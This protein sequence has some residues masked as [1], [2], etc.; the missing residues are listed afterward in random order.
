MY[1]WK[2]AKETEGIEAAGPYSRSIS[3]WE[4]LLRDGTTSSNH[5]RMSR[6]SL[7]SDVAH[8]FT[9]LFGHLRSGFLISTGH[10][11]VP[12]HA[13]RHAPRDP[14]R[15]RL[16][17]RAALLRPS[18]PVETSRRVPGAAQAS[19]GALPGGTQLTT[20]LCQVHFTMLLSLHSAQS[21]IA[22]CIICNTLEGSTAE[23]SPCYS[24]FESSSAESTYNCSLLTQ[25]G[26]P[27]IF[28]T[29][30]SPL[31]DH[32]ILSYPLEVPHL[33]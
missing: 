27:T 10:Q 5:F 33:L 32:V 3:R 19:R 9:S 26:H 30:F 21:S 31:F 12:P 4:A 6:G 14:P 25:R 22:A 2:E 13:R 28:V 20:S 17:A 29:A 24:V 15:V 1:Q 16:H 11:H 18:P 23:P 7:N 8:S